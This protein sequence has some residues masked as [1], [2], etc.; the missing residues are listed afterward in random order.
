LVLLLLGLGVADQR[1]L[2][3]VNHLM[4]ARQSTTSVNDEA[5]KN[6]VEGK[7]PLAPFFRETK[8]QL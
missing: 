2:L 5:F 4:V 8:Q 7:P 6:S 3:L 1:K